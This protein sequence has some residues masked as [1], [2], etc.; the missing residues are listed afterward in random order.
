MIVSNDFEEMIMPDLKGGRQVAVLTAEHSQGTTEIV[1]SLENVDAA[2]RVRSVA[3]PDRDRT[4]E[5]V[6]VCVIEDRVLDE[7]GP[8]VVDRIPENT[9]IVVAHADGGAQGEERLRG[10]RL[11]HVCVRC[12][13]VVVE[14]ELQVHELQQRERLASEERDITIDLLRLLNSQNNLHALLEDVTH[15]LRH[16]SGC[17]AVGIRLRTENGYPYYETRGIGED[18]FTQAAD[19]CGSNTCEKGGISEDENHSCFCERVI[20]GN[21]APESGCWTDYGSFYTG[22]LEQYCTPDDTGEQQRACPRLCRRAGYSSVAL[23]P[24]RHAGDTLGLIQLNSQQENVWSEDRIDLLERL[25]SALTVGLKHRRA[26][27]ELARNE[28]QLEAIMDSIPFVVMLIDDSWKIRH[29]NG[30]TESY[31]GKTPAELMGVEPGETLRCVASAETSEGC[32]RTEDC[33]TCRIRKAIGHT[34]R[35]GEPVREAEQAIEIQTEEDTLTRT[36]LCN[37][38]PLHSNDS[39]DVLVVLDDITERKRAERRLRNQEVL[40]RL[41]IKISTG[42]IS[43]EYEDVDEYIDWALGKIGTFAEVGRSYIFEIDQQNNVMSNTYEWCAEGVRSQKSR[44]QNVDPARF[45][46]FIEDLERHENIVIPDVEALSERRAELKAELLEQNVKSLVALPMFVSGELHGFVGLDWV[47]AP[48]EC[49][50]SVIS[51]LRVASG[52]FA[53]ALERKK[54]EGELKR[55]LDQLQSTQ[56]QLIAQE[57]QRALTTMASGIAHDFNNS[58]MSIMGFADLLLDKAQNDE[59]QTRLS[60]EQHFLEMIL[61]SARDAAATVRRMRKFYRPR[62]SEEYT[63]LDLNEIIRE[64]VSLSTPKWKQ[65]AEASGRNISVETNPGDIGPIRGNESELHELITNLIFNSVDAINTEGQ[66]SVTTRQ[67]EDRVILEV[68]DDGNGMDQKTLDRCLDPFYTTKGLEGTGLGLSTVNGIVQRHEGEITIN[69][70]LDRGTLVQITFPR[71]CPNTEDE[72]EQHEVYDV[73]SARYKILVA[74]DQEEQRRVI[75]D[76]LDGLGHTVI[77]SENGNEALESFY[78]GWFDLVLLD[79]AMP[80]MNG[81]RLA[82]LIKDE[83]PDKP[84]IMLTGFGDIMDVTDEHPEAVDLI[85]SKPVGTEKLKDAI[86]RVMQ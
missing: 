1:K 54:R 10:R 5:V 70:E 32:Q 68:Q 16:W 33:T 3:D 55:T 12:L 7:Q 76:L 75:T 8:D 9:Q 42:F 77:A 81:D 50:E 45:P 53:S 18:F 29:I 19:L 66:I 71:A 62:D 43:V 80:K 40:E 30:S 86:K 31:V 6:D 13:P 41:I 46:E 27:G 22:N 58:L 56:Q 47:S 52:A 20:S 26:A 84:V 25:A 11:Q 69:S 2:C 83:V 85:I 17:P 82:R 44:L 38:N 74:E 28:E 36:L 15:L 37:T 79:R 14:K 60:E 67:G 59:S 63:R 23:I 78:N 21:V 49:S 64:S 34:M 72:T 51:L 61:T 73:Q 4:F 39:Q 35:R 65:Q 48:H 57:R 24:L